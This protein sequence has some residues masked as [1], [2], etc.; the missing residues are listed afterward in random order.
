MTQRPEPS[1]QDLERAAGLATAVAKAQTLEAAHT[2]IVSLVRVFT[3]ADHVFF[4]IEGERGL[5]SVCH[6]GDVEPSDTVVSLAHEEAE[7]ALARLERQRKKAQEAG[8]PIPREHTGDT[9]ELPSCATA[10]W[11]GRQDAGVLA[12]VRRDQLDFFSDRELDWFRRLADNASGGLGRRY[13]EPPE[14]MP[15]APTPDDGEIPEVD[16]ELLAAVQRLAEGRF[17]G[18]APS[19][20]NAMIRLARVGPTDEPILLLGETGTGKEGFAR[21]AHECSSR[22]DKPFVVLDASVL[23]DK[24]VESE[25]FGHVKGAFTGA[26]SD[27]VGAFEQ[28]DGGTIFIDEFGELPQE[29]QVKLLRVL[30][31]G[32]YKRLGDTRVRRSNFRLIVATNAA[33][34]EDRKRFRRDVF[35]RVSSFRIILPP[36]RDRL[37]DLELLVAHFLHEFAGDGPA[38]RISRGALELLRQHDWPGNVRELRGVIRT[39]C[40]NARGR[41]TIEPGHIEILYVPEVARPSDPRAKS[42]P[43]IVRRT[44]AAHGGNRSAA[45]KE[46]GCSLR[47]IHR[48]M[49]EDEPKGQVT[50]DR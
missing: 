43:A 12:I 16:R 22:R 49:K 5:R 35:Y 34:H 21:M 36:L 6:A 38:P 50:G 2:M 39:A 44:V 19:Y 4:F 40:L 24:L 27:R 29:L 20:R 47:T 8:R 10:L 1:M 14:D 17:V 31:D 26:T 15:A 46:L 37:E 18:R 28:G 32:P 3:H 11:I 42:T 23:S 48:Y 45:A 41:T 7:G 30:Q 13:I 33:I 9:D 25:L